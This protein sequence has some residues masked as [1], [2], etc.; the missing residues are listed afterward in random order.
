MA[1]ADKEDA[2]LIAVNRAGDIFFGT[3]KIAADQL[4]NKLKDRLAKPHR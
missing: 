1:D 3:D 2:L 4:T